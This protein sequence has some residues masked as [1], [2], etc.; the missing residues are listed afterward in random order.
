MKP[1]LLRT[2]C[3]LG[4][5]LVSLFPWRCLPL[6]GRWCQRA[7]NSLDVDLRTASGRHDSILI[8][9]ALIVRQ[10]AGNCL[11]AW[12]FSKGGH[13]GTG[14]ITNLRLYTAV[15]GALLGHS[16]S[17]ETYHV[18]GEKI[19]W[20]IPCCPEILSPFMIPAVGIWYWYEV[21]MHGANGWLAWKKWALKKSADKFSS[22]DRNQWC[23]FVCSF[24]KVT[25]LSSSSCLYN[26]A[27]TLHCTQP[28]IYKWNVGW[29]C[30]HT[31]T[32]I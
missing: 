30:K 8:P 1:F 21:R 2:V 18:V 4:S 32:C 5:S 16:P 17:F 27:E 11:A 29:V 13:N 10:L 9:R 15:P 23:Q 28:T 31:Y 3:F 22:Y 12:N 20:E 14:C 26:I 7:S 24:V 19:W 6:F 25:C